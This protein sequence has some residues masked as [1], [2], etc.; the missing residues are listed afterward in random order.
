VHL[1]L[2]TL[3]SGKLF[4]LDSRSNITS[5]PY[6]DLAPKAAISVSLVRQD[7]LSRQQVNPLPKETARVAA[8]ALT[9]ESATG[10]GKKGSPTD[11]PLPA[12]KG[13]AAAPA[14]ATSNA[15]STSAAS[16]GDSSDAPPSSEKRTLANPAPAISP[17]ARRESTEI[18]PDNSTQTTIPSE[19][20]VPVKVL[21]G[22]SRRVNWLA[23][24]RSRTKGAAMVN[25]KKSAALAGSAKEASAEGTAVSDETSQ[26]APPATSSSSSSSSEIS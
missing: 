10:D 18:L 11:P 19:A 17:G 1:L 14:P 7:R 5:V 13:A 16:E 4:R 26:S 12:G 24:R 9:I 3:G 2:P 15:T 25:D 21:K 20:K 22:G 23:D 6:T 8:M